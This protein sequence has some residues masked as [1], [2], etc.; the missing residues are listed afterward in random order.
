MKPPKD[1]TFHFLSA[2]VIL[3]FV[4]AGFSTLSD[5]GMGWDEITR[6]KSGDR[7][8]EHYQQLF[9][10]SEGAPENRMSGDRY[11][12]LFDLPLAAFHAAFGGNRMLQGHSLSI[13]FGALGLAATGWLACLVFGARVGFLSVLIL[14]IFP[15]FYGHAMVNPKDIPFLAG[16]TLGLATVFWIASAL[17]AGKTPRWWQFVVCGIAIGMAGSSRVPGLALLG[18]AAGVW[19][20]AA[21]RTLY[22]PDVT[23]PVSKIILRLG[24]GLLLSGLAAFLVVLVFFPRVQFQL[25]SSLPDVATRL[26]SSAKS[27]PLLFN[28]E[29]MDASEAPFAYPLR[30][31][32]ISTPLW[33]LL[34][35]VAGLSVVLFRMSKPG[36]QSHQWIRMLL[37]LAAAAFP[38]AYILIIQPAIHDGLRHVL[39]AVPP[40]IILMAYGADSA[41]RLIERK[42]AALRLPA[43]GLGIGL[44][45][46]QVHSL[47]RMHPYQYVSFNILAG[48]RATIPNRYDTEYWCTSSRHLLEALPDVVE[49]KPSPDNPTKI[50]VSGALDAARPFVPKGFVLTDSFEEAAYYVSNTNFRID[51]IVDG[52]VLYQITRGGIPIGVIKKLDSP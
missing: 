21:L 36:E 50:R 23:V 13:L 8:L 38:W 2:F 10:D 16:Y 7:K 1:A 11:P 34:L 42:S 47:Y 14:A 48:H 51:A 4:A 39:F 32:M 31:F 26:H 35:L 40:L 17:L 28:G 44:V 5:Y 49:S 52:E 22:R 18:I 20:V 30:F 25:F 46:F 43:L 45:L 9:S 15:R 19:A 6:W 29:I 12:G 33:M 24:G 41:F 27:M 37:F 3:L